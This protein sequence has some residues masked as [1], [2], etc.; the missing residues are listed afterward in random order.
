MNI[1]EKIDAIM[2]NKND[3]IQKK[4]KLPIIFIMILISLLFF[5]LYSSLFFEINTAYFIMSIFTLWIFYPIINI[6][7]FESSFF[8]IKI[9]NIVTSLI[10][11]NNINILE[12]NILELS[13]RDLLF[14]HTIAIN[15]LFS[16]EDLFYFLI[17]YDKSFPNIKNYIINDLYLTRKN[18]IAFINH[19]IEMFLS[20]QYN[21]ET[22]PFILDYLMKN[23]EHNQYITKIKE[24][25]KNK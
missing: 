23:D 1:I 19:K 4:K 17:G 25:I 12:D 2:Q 22:Y 7:F 14:N 20:S 3:I 10:S 8:D 21:T 24:L 13:K 15:T 11:Y 9:N 16:S 5:I 18:K 6:Y